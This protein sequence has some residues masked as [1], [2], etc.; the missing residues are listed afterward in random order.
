MASGTFHRG[1]RIP[2]A[3]IAGVVIMATGAGGCH[4]APVS[5]AAQPRPANQDSIRAA[6]ARRDSLARAEQARLAAAA[7]E[8]ARADSIRRAADAAN[9]A[10]SAD[11][12]ARQALLAPVYFDYDRAE[13]RD[14]Q[15]RTLDQKVSLLTANRSLQLR[16]EGNTDERGSDEYNLALGMRRAAAVRRYFADRGI[17]SLRVAIASNGEERPV[18]QDHE[19]AC[20]SR[21]RR[22]E[23]IIA[24]GPSRLIS[25]K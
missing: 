11:A 1:R 22:D 9:A 21:N 23:F 14:D 15:R 3:I 4:K 2:A 18:C 19:E 12:A 8:Q 13:L 25:A 24:G 5:V 10:A 17:D 6:N 20:R 16:V 7:R